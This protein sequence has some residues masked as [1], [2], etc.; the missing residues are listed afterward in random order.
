M[1]EDLIYFGLGGAT[2]ASLAEFLHRRSSPLAAAETPEP[3]AREDD[4]EGLEC[5]IAA[6]RKRRRNEDLTRDAVKIL[7]A[8]VLATGGIPGKES[9]PGACSRGIVRE[10]RVLY[11]E[12]ENPTPPPDRD[13]DTGNA[14][15]ELSPEDM[16]MDEMFDGVE[17]AGSGRDNDNE[18]GLL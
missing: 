6:A 5:I 7:R 11:D 4:D 18:E 2:G 12:I 3:P 8:V 16:W 13:N 15:E 17:D 1:I 9:A 14:D 10:L